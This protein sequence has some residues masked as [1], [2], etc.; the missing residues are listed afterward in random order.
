MYGRNLSWSN[1]WQYYN[2][3]LEILSGTT[4]TL[5]Q[6]SQFTCRESNREPHEYTPGSLPFSA[7][8]LVNSVWSKCPLVKNKFIVT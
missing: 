8:I 4:E 2:A 3:C 1:R 7:N 6:G 5:S